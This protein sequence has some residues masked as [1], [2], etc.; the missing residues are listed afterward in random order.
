MSAKEVTVDVISING[1]SYVKQSSVNSSAPAQSVDGMPY[2][3]VRTKDSGVFA[4]Y[5]ADTSDTTATVIMKNARRLWYWSGAAS[6]SE[7]SQK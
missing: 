2:V 5:L 7:L 3:I 4:G 1:E 6:L